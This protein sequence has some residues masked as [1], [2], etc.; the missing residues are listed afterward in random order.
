[1]PNVSVALGPRSYDIVIGQNLLAHA[2]QFVQS[3]L[4]ASHVVVVTDENVEPLYGEVVLKSLAG[5]TERCDMVGIP[6]GETSKSV[7]CLAALWEKLLEFG[8]DRK[9]A[10]VALGGG[11][12]GDLAGF[13]AASYA[14]G[15]AFLQIP[16]TLLAQVD[17]SVGGKTGINLSTAKN[18]V[19]AFWQPR[20]VLID[21]N[22]LQSQTARDFASGLAEVIKYGVIQDA[23]FFEFLEA[24]PAQL[25]ARDAETLGQVV[26]RC[27]ELK[28]AVVTQDEREETGLR[29]I[30]N[31]G[32]TF[33]HALEAV[34]GYGELLHGEAV[35]IGMD[36]AARLAMRLGRI[37]ASLVE[38]QRALLRG[39]G[40]PVTVPPLDLDALIQSMSHDKKVEHGRLRFVLPS[41]L[42]HVELVGDI[43]PELVREILAGGD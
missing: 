37:D 24:H 5:V 15:L 6:A 13:L 28:A 29:A 17:S 36:C 38:R 33:A 4:R 23:E 2:G 30:L 16:T 14:R 9:S 10:I 7:D 8:T 26:A 41:R 32:H 40:L 25:L 22:T 35:A 19:G 31:Y 1:M 12:V 43:P 42:G 21:T 39:V 20:G 27:C 18:L 3:R 11:V 34:S